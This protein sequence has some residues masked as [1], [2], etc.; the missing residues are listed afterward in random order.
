MAT[1]ARTAPHFQGGGIAAAVAG[2]GA[3]GALVATGFT[4][5]SGRAVMVPEAHR[6]AARRNRML[7]DVA[8]QGEQ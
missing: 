4:R 5:G 1:R 6:E 2:A 3:G 8:G 7:H